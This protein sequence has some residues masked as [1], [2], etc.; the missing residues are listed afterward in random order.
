MYSD[1]ESESK[2]NFGSSAA[3]ETL[4][5]VFL[6]LIIVGGLMVYLK[7]TGKLSLP[8]MGQ[9]ISQFGRD[10]KSVRRIR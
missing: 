5:I 1:S 9:R 7:K 8:T 3:S 10:I 2:S 4:F 6:L